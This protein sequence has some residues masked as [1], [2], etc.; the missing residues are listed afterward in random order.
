MVIT[1]AEQL[2]SAILID[3]NNISY[4]FKHVK[5]SFL[6]EESLLRIKGLLKRNSTFVHD[7]KFTIDFTP[8]S[9]RLCPFFCSLQSTKV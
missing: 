1:D 2:K 3:N 5:G 4:V 8:A 9:K 7:G 6:L